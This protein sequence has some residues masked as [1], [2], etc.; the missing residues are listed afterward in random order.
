MCKDTSFSPFSINCRKKI[1]TFTRPVVIGIL[2]ATSDS[3]YDGGHYTTRETILRRA[4]QIVDEGADIIDIGVVSSRPGAQLLEP[5][6]EARRLAP[7]VDMIRQALPNAILSVDTC[8]AQPARKAIEAGADI[9][10]DIS[11]GQFDKEMMPTVAELQVPYILMHTQ[12]TPDHMQDNPHYNDILQEVT[13]YFSERVDRLRSLGV[14]DIILDPG[15]GFAKSIDDNY[16]LFHQLPLLRQ[17]FPNI[18]LLVAI[19]RKS[20][21]YR[22]CDTT[23]DESLPGTLTLDTLALEYGA[24]MIRVHDVKSAVQSVKVWQKIHSFDSID[25]PQTITH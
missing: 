24:Q 11:G 3:F 19:S 6:E 15:F 13:Y 10:N 2:N 5:G 12:G 1:I 21:I 23:P 7:I 16:L 8:F 17:L 9:V 22:L 4:H 20:M 18:P 14:K 25:T